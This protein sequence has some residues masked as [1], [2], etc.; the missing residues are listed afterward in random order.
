MILGLLLV[1]LTAFSMLNVYC[2]QISPRNRYFGATPKSVTDGGIIVCGSMGEVANDP[3]LTET[4]DVRSKEL[5]FSSTDSLSNQK[6]VVWTEI[7]LNAA[8]QL[9]Q[10]TAW[11]VRIYS[12]H[13]NL[14]RFTLIMNILFP[15]FQFAQTITV[16]P[17]NIEALDKTETYTNFYDIFVRHAFGNFRD[18]LD[19]YVFQFL[20]SFRAID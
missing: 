9:R 17:A 11:A 8:D 16:V 13:S 4:F 5:T 7:A 14:N 18:I 6:K 3:T 1:A 2:H 15:V 20:C 19:E 12:T 10:R